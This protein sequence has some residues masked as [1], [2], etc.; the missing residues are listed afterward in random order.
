MDLASPGQIKM[1]T[2]HFLYAISIPFNS[3]PDVPRTIWL[4]GLALMPRARPQAGS[5]SAIS[6]KLG[7]T[8]RESTTLNNLL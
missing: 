5:F 4:P 7:M 1:S 2:V 3:K 6:P 8:H